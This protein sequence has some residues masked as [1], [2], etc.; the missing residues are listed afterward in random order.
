MDWKYY[1]PHSWDREREVWEDIY[2]LPVED[3]GY[4]GKALWLTINALGDV[5]TVS[6][7]AEMQ[8]EFLSQ[9][10]DRD[11]YIDGTEMIVKAIDLSK[12]ELLDWVRV[13]LREHRLPIANLI[14]APVEEFRHKAMYADLV[15]EYREMMNIELGSNN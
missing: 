2:L 12:I 13:W 14:E 1:I 6:E 9:L 5:D 3:I 15:V 11:Y 8:A 7:R 10:G 4:D